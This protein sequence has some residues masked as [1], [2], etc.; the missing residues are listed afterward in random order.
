MDGVAVSVILPSLNVA[1]YIRE[2]ME[3]VLNQTLTNIEIICIDAGSTDGT[4]EILQQYSSEDDRIVLVHSD[5]KSYGAQVNQGIK[6]SKGKYI[7]I[8]ETDDYIRRDMYQI[9]FNLAEQKCVEYVKG[10]Y[11]RFCTLR[12]GKRI[13]TDSKQFGKDEKLYN[14]ILNPHKQDYLYKSD[15][16]I[17]RGIYLATF[18]KDNRIFLTESLGAAYQDIGFME[19]VLMHAKTA[20]YIDECLYFYRT[21]RDNA[22]TYSLNALRN[23]YVE[24][25]SFFE[26]KVNLSLKVYKRGYYLHFVTSFLTE[27]KKVLIKAEFDYTA[28]EI[29]NYYPWFREQLK[30]VLSSGFISQR[31]FSGDSYE[32]LELLLSSPSIFADEIKNEQKNKE[33]FF[34]RLRL[35]ETTK[36]VIFGA[37]YWG[38]EILKYLDAFQSVHVVAFADND[39]NKIGS[40]IAGIQVDRLD[41]C[42]RQ[43]PEA[44]FIITNESHYIE[45]KK[46]FV[47]EGGDSDKVICFW[48]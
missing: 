18:I 9:L 4:W 24:F 25:K 37:G 1:P 28:P 17:W 44:I 3:S 48:E 38:K 34:E 23:T 29:A 33:N 30:S 11:T 45:M 12:S 6:I 43:F 15:F 14:T 36:V 46:Q 32:K 42:I 2:C 26:N 27:Y 21:D 47:Q 35:N 5:I 10:D 16:N 20:C 41:E 22:S 40:K 31:D 8:L 13:F 19:Q 39:K 7:A